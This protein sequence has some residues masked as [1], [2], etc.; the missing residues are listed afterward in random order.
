MSVMQEQYWQEKMDSKAF[1]IN[2]LY[3]LPYMML[4]GVAGAVL[5]SGL[6]LLI[7]MVASREPVYYAETEYY[8]DFADGQLEA[9]HHYND[10]TWNDVM[11]HN[12]ILGRSMEVLGTSY[13]KEVVKEMITADIL[14]DVR[15]LTITVRGGNQ[16]EVAKVSEVTRQS[17]AA[18]GQEK[19]EFDSITQVEDNGV[20]LEEVPLFTWRA[21]VLGFM[22]GF[23]AA[24]LVVCVKLSIGDAVYTKEQIEQYFGIP[25]LGILYQG[26]EHAL[27][28]EK[29][30]QQCKIHWEYLCQKR[31]RTG[32]VLLLEVNK[33]DC[34]KGLSYQELREQAGIV[35][36]IPFGKACRARVMD[37]IQELKLQDC[38]ILGA[39]LVD[40]DRKWFRM[41]GLGKVEEK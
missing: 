13:D 27:E 5:G 32:E 30:M 25:A 17:L 8:V 2:L 28:N 29:G 10:F 1:L 20:R 18:F 19:E 16:E 3:R 36:Q 15:Y 41:Y 11:A 40:A 39:I 35:L 9:K 21:L 12:G 26:T 6:Y 14:S 34:Y 22:V 33:Q 24:L 23:L 37:S 7:A 4:I 31:E 38:V